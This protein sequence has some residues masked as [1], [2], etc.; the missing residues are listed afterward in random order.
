MVRTDLEDRGTK[1]DTGAEADF[2]F[3]GYGTSELV[4]CYEDDAISGVGAGWICRS[5]S[6]ALPERFERSR[7]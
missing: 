3:N 6:E 2:E 4:P 5:I 1:P 7:S